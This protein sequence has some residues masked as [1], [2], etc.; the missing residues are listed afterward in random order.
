[1][2]KKLL[3]L[4][5]SLLF[6]LVFAAGSWASAFAQ[7]DTGTESP[8][9]QTAATTG[10]QTFA[11]GNQGIFIPGGADP[12]FVNV[13]LVDKDTTGGGVVFFA[14]DPIRIEFTGGGFQPLPYVFF[15]LWPWQ[16]RAYEDGRLGIYGQNADGTWS[17]C[18][19]FL[20]GAPSERDRGTVQR[21]G[22][23]ITNSGVWGIGS[24]DKGDRPVLAP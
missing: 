13:E 14:R 20:V 17:A 11:R 22:C 18:N 2:N 19:A 8:A 12:D 7:D 23:V 21:I 24:M 10:Q 15:E 6:V 5:A 16:V 9:Q 3:K 4:T 1:M